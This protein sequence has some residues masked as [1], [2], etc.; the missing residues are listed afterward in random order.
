MDVLTSTAVAMAVLGL[1]MMSSVLLTRVAGR[2][3]IP[4]TL[5]FLI[6]GMLAGSEG[7]GHIA[8][9]DYR[10]TLR[11]GTV[12][13]V[14]ILFDGGLNTSFAAVRRALAPAVTLAT[15]GVVLTILLISVAARQ[16]NFSWPS[17]LLLGSIVSSTDAAALFAILRSSRISLARRMAITLELESG[18]NDPIAVI[19]TVALSGWQTGQHETAGELVLAVL[20]QLAAGMAGG[21]FIGFVGRWLLQRARPTATGLL[22]VFT[23]ALAFAAYGVTTL[24]HGSGFLA[25]YTAG[26]V[27]GNGAMPYRTGILR[28]HD[29]A[30]WLGQ[31]VM[32]LVLG[33]LSTPSRLLSVG[34][35][36]LSLALIL[37]VLAR[38]LAVALCLLPF[39]FQ[40]REVAF[41][42]WVGLRGAVPIILAIVPRLTGAPEAAHIFDVVFFIVVVSAFIP[43]ATLGRTARLL[44]VEV[45][46]VPPPAAML[47]IASAQPLGGDVQGCYVSASSAA[48]GARIDELPLPAGSSLMLILRADEPVVPQPDLLLTAGDHVFVFCPAADRVEVALLFGHVDD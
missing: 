37:A 25:S 14:L 23:V 4:V 10:L 48:V 13:L 40:T 6:I 16:L 46:G 7:V 38:P 22:P 47:E 39:R 1:L 31:V 19:L 27:I 28:V 24:A 18:L 43:G 36:G 30:A 33:L 44:G 45:H 35:V 15:V 8:F 21:L 26:V 29:A 41:V 42:G 17:A 11:L 2:L 3:S 34:V 5:L 12:I 9:E 32:F 20:L